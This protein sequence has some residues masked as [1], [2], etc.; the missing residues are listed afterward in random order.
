MRSGGT[1]NLRKAVNTIRLNFEVRSDTTLNWLHVDRNMISRQTQ[2][3]V[4]YIY[5]CKVV[6]GFVS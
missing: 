1:C 3:L 4:S 2:L 6:E 5:I